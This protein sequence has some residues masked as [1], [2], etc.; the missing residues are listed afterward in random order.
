MKPDILEAY[1]ERV[2]AYAIKRTFNREE[3]DELSQEILFVAV[4]ELARLRDESCFEAWLWGIAANVTRSFRRTMGKAHAI[5]SYNTIELDEPCDSSDEDDREPVYDRLRTEV[6]MLS[7]TWRD[8]IVLHYYD[9]LSIKEISARLGIPEGTVTWRL[10]EAR[11][12]LKKECEN[13]EETALKPVKLKLDIYGSGNFSAGVPMPESYINDALSQ[14][15]L[16]HCYD[17]A[18]TVEELAKLCGVPA[19][20]IED[21]LDNL[22][23]REAMIKP[24]RGKYQTDFVI[25]SDKYGI[26]CEENAAGAVEP[27]AERMYAALRGLE[28]DANMIGI[29][30]AEKSSEELIYLY[31]AM[32]FDCLCRSYCKLPYPE[33]KPSYDGNNWRYV[34][35]VETGKHKR[36]GVGKCTCNNLGSRGSYAHYVYTYAGTTIRPMM[37]DTY[38]N[39]CEDILTSGGTTDYDNAAAAISEGYIE[40]RGDELFVTVPAFTKEQKAIFDESVVRHFAPL[41][42]EYSR[43]AERFIAGYAKLFPRHLADDAARFSRQFFFELLAPLAEIWQTNGLISKPERGL[44]CDVMVQFK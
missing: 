14:N 6:A 40:R 43:I 29:Y 8:I 37:Y 24:A 41:M 4:R 28:A 9:G 2:Y 20:Y 25:W 21:R 30:H 39:V 15:I 22:I 11:K 10:S 16:Y 17:E 19:Y 18:H 33:I 23:K 34:G 12:K 38:I 26:Y 13:M 7:K 5:Y 32:A 3:A 35:S 1:V 31:A 36:S 44:V 27:I 42:D